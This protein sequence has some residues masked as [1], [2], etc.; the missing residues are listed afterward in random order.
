MKE[1]NLNIKKNLN[2]FIGRN[3][4]AETKSWLAAENIGFEEHPFIRIVLSEPGFQ[5]FYSKDKKPEQFVVSS[6]WA[7]KWLVKYKT[8]IGFKKNDSIFCLSERQR[9]ICSTISGNIFVAEQPNAFSLAHLAGAM[10]SGKRMVYLHGNRSLNDFETEM[11]SL[12]IG[13]Q[14]IEVYQ[15]LPVLKTLSNTFGAYLFFSPSGVENFVKSGNLIPSA[16]VISVI[17][18]TTAKTCERLFCRE[19]FISKTQEELAAVQ[20]AAGF[21]KHSEIRLNTI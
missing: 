19:I 13:V 8:E 11:T 4:S 6:Q 18:T 3:I 12:G 17:G 5:L 9:E 7:A 20:F 14:K 2:L 1:K 15:N 21:L 16:S 10:N